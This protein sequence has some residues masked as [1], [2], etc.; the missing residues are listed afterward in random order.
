MKC[1]YELAHVQ[2]ERLAS[3]RLLKQAEA[4]ARTSEQAIANLKQERD[5]LQAEVKKLY[6]E[7][8]QLKKDS[9]STNTTMHAVTKRESESS[10]DERSASSSSES[11][12]DTISRHTSTL[13]QRSSTVRPHPP[14]FREVSSRVEKFSGKRAE[15]GTFEVWLDDF[16]EATTDCGWTDDMRARW[17]SWFVS[18]P[19]KA[20]WQRTLTTEQKRDWKSIV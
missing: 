20:T 7:L 11:A 8:L 4:R 5:A 10:E 16:E 13:V 6:D 12:E 17:F 14:G 3:A 18:G 2:D 19:A 1:E 15:D 9:P